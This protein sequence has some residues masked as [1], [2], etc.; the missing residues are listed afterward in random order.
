M[1]KFTSEKLIDST[2]SVTSDFQHHTPCSDCPWRRDA[3]PGWLG[4]NTVDEWLHFAHTDTHIPCHTVRN[5]QCAGS[6][7][8]RRNT[9]K[10][11]VPPLLVLRADH[12]LVFSNRVEFTDH[13]SKKPKVSQKSKKRT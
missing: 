1:T 11:V 10:M 12:A 7:I 8:Y 5:V 13:H 6:A 4:G 2:E 9:C 3:L